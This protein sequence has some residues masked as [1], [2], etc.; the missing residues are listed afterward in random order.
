MR[1]E[2]GPA[3]SLQWN[4]DNP[5]T[6]EPGSR[7]STREAYRLGWALIWPVAL[8]NYCFWGL[9]DMF[10]VSG[11]T[12]TALNVVLAVF[13][14]LP[15]MIRRAF[16]SE[17]PRFH[18]AIRRPETE[19]LSRS[20]KYRESL[21]LSVLLTVFTSG[22]AALPLGWIRSLF[23]T[24]QNTGLIIINGILALATLSLPVWAAGVLMFDC[25]NA[26]SLRIVRKDPVEGHET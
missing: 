16:Q 26:F 18:L 17:F 5:R 3:M 6:A 23:A 4:V 12:A 9:E 13:L 1:S 24:G 19:D 8:L 10:E 15:K 2:G 7:L 25:S 11:W 20:M 21:R 14:W 22:L